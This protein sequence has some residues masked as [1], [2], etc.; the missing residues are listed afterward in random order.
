MEFFSLSKEHDIAIDMEWIP[1]SDNEVAYYLSKIV[2]F[3]DR[4][5]KDSYFQAVCHL[6]PIYC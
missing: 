4:G 5:V 3:D 2:D 1:H 6:G